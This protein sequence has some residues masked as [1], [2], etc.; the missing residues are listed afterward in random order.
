MWR[1]DEWPKYKRTMGNAYNTL[2]EIYEAG[3][4]AM[5]EGQKKEGWRINGDS[6]I[7]ASGGFPEIHIPT[8]MRGWLV[9]IPNEEEPDETNQGTTVHTGKFDS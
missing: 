7:P 8:G 3:A 9:F 1:P 4:D 5:L 6:I 2:G